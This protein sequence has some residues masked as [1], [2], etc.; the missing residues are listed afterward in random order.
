MVLEIG[1]AV[2][3]FPTDFAVVAEL[4]GVDLHVSVE[5]ILVDETFLTLIAGKTSIRLFVVRP[6]AAIL[7]VHTV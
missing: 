1:V 7:L 5:V 6:L 3:S 2:E 4:P